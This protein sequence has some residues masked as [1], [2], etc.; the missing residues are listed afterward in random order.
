MFADL[1]DTTLRTYFFGIQISY[2]N[3]ILFIKYQ[4]IYTDISTSNRGNRQT[5]L[6]SY[7]TFSTTAM[8]SM[9]L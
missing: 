4:N 1:N 3:I 2:T 8:N 7:N 5:V 9:A 6:P